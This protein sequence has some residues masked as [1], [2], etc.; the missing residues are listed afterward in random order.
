M[1]V[2]INPEGK[3]YIKLTLLHVEKNENASRRIKKAG[4]AGFLSFSFHS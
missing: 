2:F 3:E 1:L 4:N